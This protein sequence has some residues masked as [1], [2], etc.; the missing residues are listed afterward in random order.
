MF[1]RDGAAAKRQTAARMNER[2]QRRRRAR[3]FF[4]RC[5]GLLAV[6]LPWMRGERPLPPGVS[7]AGPPR[8]LGTDGA[9]LLLD[10][11]VWNPDTAARR[12]EQEIFETVLRRIG[13]ARRLLVMDWFLWNGWRGRGAEFHRDISAELTA[14]LIEKRR[15]SP[16]MDLLVLTDPINRIYDGHEAADLR[17]LRDAGIPVVYTDVNRLRPTNRVFT[18]PAE[19]FAP[20]FSRVGPLRRWADRP[21]IKN[22]FDIAEPPISARQMARL[23]HFRANH[24]KLL[25][26]D[27]ESGALRLLIG[28]FNPSSASSAHVNVA[29]ECGGPVALDA[30]ASELAVIEWSLA[31]DYA[32]PAAET[33][34]ARETLDRIRRRCLAEIAALPA[35][36]AQVEGPRVQ[37]LGEGAI[38]R[39]LLERLDA[40]R[41]GD[42]ARVALFYLSDRA[43]LR[44]LRGAARRGARIRL[45]LDPNRDAFGL[46]KNGIPNR[47]LAAGLAAYGARA[48]RN[49]MI[50][51]ADT[52]GEQFHAK[53]VLFTF[54]DGPPELLAGSANWTSRN[55]RDRNLEANVLVIGD[56][57]VAARFADAFDAAWENRPGGLCRTREY[58]A[59]A[60]SPAARLWK[61][62][63]GYL[64]EVTGASSF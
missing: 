14:A 49:L 30:L 27:D 29:L 2:M 17:A 41:S 54:A 5:C 42:E 21:R 46:E 44:A 6:A 9:R 31:G 7:L 10:R 57:A 28:S 18:P 22:P 15:A 36:D 20:L 13:E 52:H 39:R 11:T 38:H 33:Q 37:W 48:G 51:W 24:R 12:I 19:F 4:G 3:R 63:L 45:I 59:F 25:V 32:P 8:P 50:R 62:P 58:A 23:L 34:R 56:A 40:L 43:V 61:A 26:A 16:D 35:A 64:Q 1:V 53:A 55:L 47:P 60:E